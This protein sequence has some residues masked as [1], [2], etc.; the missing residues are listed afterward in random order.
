[1]CGI[2]GYSHLAGSLPAGLLTTALEA[3]AHRGPDHHGTLV[4]GVVKLMP[5][6]SLE[7][8][9]GRCRVHSFV[10][11]SD[12]KKPPNSIEAACDELDGLLTQ[13]LKEQL[14]SDL[15]VGIWLSGG[16]DRAFRVGCEGRI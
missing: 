3:L 6:H 5:G 12:A 14:V 11:A 4:E 7:W 16:L 13:S 9:S 1:M 15:P 2:L 10:T 8:R